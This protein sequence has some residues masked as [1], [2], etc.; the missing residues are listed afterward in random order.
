Q[1]NGT[2]GTGQTIAIVDAFG[3]RYATVTATTN[4]VNHKQLITYTTNITDSTQNDWT[5]FCNQFGLVTSGLNVVY[6]QGQGN[7]ST[8]W[9]LETALDIQW[10]HAIAPGANILLVVAR[11]SSISNMYAAVDYAVSAG[12]NIVSM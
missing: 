4:I 11:D 3:D 2:D 7:V 5:T 1:L 9:A 8:N 12:A 6:P 10:A